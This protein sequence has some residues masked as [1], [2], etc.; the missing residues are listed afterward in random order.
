[1][2]Y[3]ILTPLLLLPLLASTGAAEPPVDFNRDI[4]PLL[5][6]NCF[7]CHGPDAAE[8]R[9]DLRLDD[10]HSAFAELTTGGFAIVPGEASVSEIIRR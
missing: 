5:S 10:R 8:R 9:T 1:M 7:R 2:C 4:R 3:R 6:D